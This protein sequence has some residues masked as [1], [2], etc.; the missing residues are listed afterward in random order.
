MMRVRLAHTFAVLV[1]ALAHTPA[2]AQTLAKGDGVDVSI[3]RVIISLLLCFALAAGAIF[4]LRHKFPATA[5]LKRVRGER[6][7]LVDQISLGPQRGIYLIEL[8]GKE[9]L[10]LFSQ[11]CVSLTITD[12]SPVVTSEVV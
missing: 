6:L 12:G 7:K 10:A 2:A 1:V 3:W 4:A 5:L 8:D 9:Y 11:Q